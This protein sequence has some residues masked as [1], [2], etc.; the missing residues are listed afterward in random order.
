[1][2]KAI[3][4]SLILLEDLTKFYHQD[5]SLEHYINPLLKYLTEKWNRLK[6]KIAS[7]LV[8]I[9]NNKTKVEAEGFI[10]EDFQKS[11]MAIALAEMLEEYNRDSKTTIAELLRQAEIDTI[12]KFAS[13]TV[14][15]SLSKEGFDVV[16]NS[17]KWQEGFIDDFTLD[18][19][20]RL[21]NLIKARY[22]NISDFSNTINR[23]LRIDR[24]SLMQDFHSDVEK[25]T[26]NMMSGKITTEEWK[27][28]MLDSIESNYRKLYR[29]GK[30]SALTEVEEKL[31]IN[32]VNTQISYLKDFGLSVD[33]QKTIGK[34]L[35]DNITW[36]AGLYAERGSAL[37]EAGYLAS[38]PDDVIVDWKLHVAEHCTSCKILARNSPY[39]KNTLPCLP[40]DGSTICRTN[41]K[42]S[43]EISSYYSDWTEFQVEYSPITGK[44]YI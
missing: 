20:T 22:G 19:E 12:P 44:K 39:L 41:C 38:L 34:E 4:T 26:R 23:T 28:Q 25:V 42:C 21:N 6:I 9:A 15:I 35:K 43:L 11:M 10:L 2:T 3:E 37:F 8:S 32:Q 30:G 27:I 17:L 18:A 40:G 5:H 33:I 29:N 16:K 7:E 36:R 13:G 31:I 1:M 14:A 24:D